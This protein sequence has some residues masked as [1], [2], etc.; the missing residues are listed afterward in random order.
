[1]VVNVPRRDIRAASDNQEVALSLLVVR[2]G[3]EPTR[4]NEE[5]WGAASASVTDTYISAVVDKTICST[6]V[7]LCANSSPRAEP[8]LRH[9]S[10]S[11]NSL[12]CSVETDMSGTAPTTR[13]SASSSRPGESHSCSALLY[14]VS[15]RDGAD[16]AE[17]PTQHAIRA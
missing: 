12:P 3:G 8:F 5:Q 2:W 14:R 4:F 13:S 11:Q 1:M 17:L 15:K 10:T 9:A 16:N 6:L 7:F